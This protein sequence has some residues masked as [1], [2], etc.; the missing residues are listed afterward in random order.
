MK[1]TFEFWRIIKVR[2]ICQVEIDIPDQ[3][4]KDKYLPEAMAQATYRTQHDTM[5]WENEGSIS[6]EQY[7][8]QRCYDDPED[9]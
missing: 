7:G 6:V 1:V 4:Q 9:E 8:N 2:Q 3:L 5:P